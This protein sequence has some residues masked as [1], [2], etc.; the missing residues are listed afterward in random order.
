MKQ[1]S[2]P[3]DRTEAKE[4]IRDLSKQIH[5]HRNLYYNENEPEIPDAE[6][7]RLERELE[8]LESTWPDL[9]SEDSPTQT[10]G[11]WIGREFDPVEHRLPMLS[12]SNAFSDDEVEAFNQR[13]IDR[14]DHDGEF[15][16]AA[17]PKL[18][19]LAISLMYENG[20]LTQAATRG[21][22]FTGENVTHT[23]R[24]IDSIPLQL[25][26]DHQGILEVRGEVFFPIAAF[27]AHNEQA[28]NSGDKVFANPRNAAAGSLRLLDATVTATRPLDFYAYSVGHTEGYDLPGQHSALLA[29]LDGYGLPVCPE[30]AVVE[31]IAGCHEFYAA[32][33]ERRD[34]LPYEIDGVVFK[35]DDVELQ[36]ALGFVSRAPRWAIAR[37][38]PAQE[39][40]TLVEGIDIQVGRTGALTPVARLKPVFVG[41]VTVTNATLH[42]IDEIRRKDVRVGDTVIVRRAGDVIPEVVSVVMAMRHHNEPEFVM[43]QR[44]PECGSAAE[45]VEDEAV[46]RCTGG[47]ICPAQQREAFRHFVSRKAMDIDGLGEK[48]VV[49]LMD[50]G[51]VS[52]VADLYR[53]NR[54]DVV[55]L[56]RMAEKSA[57]NLLQAIDRS[58]DTTLARF[59]FALGI[60]E[61]G[62]TTARLLASTLG[63]I[64]AISEASLEELEAIPDIGP[65]MAAHIHGFFSEPGNLELIGQF[66]DIGLQLPFTRADAPVIE[67]DTAALPLAGNTYVLTGKLTRFTR[68]Q[69]KEALLALGARVSGSVSAR[70]TAL[71]AGEAAGSKLAR[72]EKLEIPVMS[73]DDL[74]WLL[75]NQ[76]G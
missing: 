21:D 38:F 52:T 55:A 42:N 24:T 12:L 43:P 47:L 1:S 63:S 16:F 76:S 54:D 27:N 6:F 33:A 66:R 40:L 11:N 17:E 32:L 75:D 5:H 67:T 68:S 72:A 2:K 25:I 46:T 15:K 48:L 35:V 73:E 28:R 44:C 56:E 49:Q 58:R 31:G 62:E 51:L 64:E 57:D 50:A 22:G 61:V 26:G 3:M 9:V 34:A 70:T 37:K 10:V 8:A 14:I 7:D 18:D 60:R 23:V 30:N 59:L 74:A 13:C 69:A 53:L 65:I 41:G 20:I 29:M 39:E 71:I 4:R 45:R 19:G 36:E